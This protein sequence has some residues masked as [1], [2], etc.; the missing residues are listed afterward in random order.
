MPGRERL[1]SEVGLGLVRER[2]RATELLRSFFALGARHP[3]L[4]ASVGAEVEADGRRQVLT[5]FVLRG[6]PGGAE[7]T[8]LG[9]FAVVHGDEPAGGWAL[10][11]L[12]AQV[13]SRPELAAGFELVL[14]P[15]CNPVGLARNTRENAGGVDLNREFWRGSTGPE[16]RWLE[17]ELRRQQFDGLVA[18]HADDTSGG[19]YG[20]ARG[21]TLAEELLRPA[22]AAASAVLPANRDRVIDGFHAVDGV[23]FDCYP[24]VLTAPP[25]QQPRPFEII[26][27]T[28][29][30]SPLSDQR[31][32]A[33]AALLS[34][35]DN[36]RRVL[37]EA[38][39]I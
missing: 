28:P 29:A 17:G 22:L 8:R 11:D 25:E 5:R 35:F 4:I 26:F 3:E 19:L 21:R 12:A 34:V 2:C 38:A 9:I 32:A 23:I 7:R 18:L 33:V 20:F 10:V 13:L 6:P 1:L 30:R 14:Y 27:E 37:G 16:A 15:C 24:G 31:Q 39:A 36:Y